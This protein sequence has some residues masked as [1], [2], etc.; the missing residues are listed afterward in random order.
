MDRTF[1]ATELVRIAKGLMSGGVVFKKTRSEPY[2][3]D[4]TMDYGT[5]TIDGKSFEAFK[6]LVAG[7][8]YIVV[9]EP[10]FKEGDK[11]STKRGEVEVVAEARPEK[12]FGGRGWRYTFANGGWIR[13]MAI[14]SLGRWSDWTI[15]VGRGD[16]EPHVKRLEERRE[17]R[18]EFLQKR[19]ERRGGRLQQ[20]VDNGTL[21]K[22]MAV[23]WRMGRLGGMTTSGTI[24]DFNF[25]TGRILVQGDIFTRMKRVWVDHVWDGE[26][27]NLYSIT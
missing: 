26:G 19:R 18:Q 10:R 7:R 13:D 9:S 23:R 20:L 4:G 16:A 22:G 27:R 24:L 1:I 5:T 17:K 6:V 14:G 25:D 2:G 11:V 3:R 12:L 21:K 8:T 15:K